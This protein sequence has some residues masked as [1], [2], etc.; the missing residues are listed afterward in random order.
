LD[1][2]S[3]FMSE[4]MQIFLIEFSVNHIRT[5]A[6]HPLS[7]GA[8][9]RLNGMLK[10]MIRCLLDCFPDSWDTALPWVLFVYRE[11]SVETL[12]YSPFELMFGCTVSG[13]LHLIKQGVV[14]FIL[15]TRERLRHALDF[16]NTQAVEE[17]S[18][19]KVWY[20]RR[21][22]LSTF[23]PGDKI[24]VLLP[25]QGKPLHAKYQGPYSVEQQLGLVD[26]VNSTPDHRKTKQVCHVDVWLIC[27]VG[28]CESQRSTANSGIHPSQRA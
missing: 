7:N 27:V 8:C 26:Y 1:Q 3:D 16:A 23:Q 6:Y 19:A 22:R 11:V 21:A 5:S 20:D 18:K 25:L 24:M 2:G 13:P 4:L 12:D 28:L 14:E 10:S 15:N 17:R 9:E